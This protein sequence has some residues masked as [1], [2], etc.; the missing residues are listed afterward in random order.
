[1]DASAENLVA[2]SGGGRDF[3]KMYDSPGDDTF[4]SSPTAASLVGSG[5]SHTAYDFFAALGYATNREGDDTA[6]GND[7][8]VMADSAQKD[9]FKFDW[10]GPKQFFGK[11][12]EG[13][14]YYTRAK[15]FEEIAANMSGG[16]DLARLFGSEG[17]DTFH[18]QRDASQMTG[19]Q[20][21][22]TVTGYNSL[23]AYAENGV[24]EAYFDDSEENDT[25]R[26]RSL[27]VMMWG[28][29]YADPTYMLTARRFDAYH[30]ERTHGGDDLAKLHDTVLDDY[31][32]VDDGIAR[33]YMERDGERELLYESIAFEWVKLYSESDRGKNTFKSDDSI[34]DLLFDPQL[35]EEMP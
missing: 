34:D 28:G 25:V 20:Y 16:K 11:M 8:A 31:V 22:V 17:D 10:N 7:Q 18:G 32:E 9:K 33:F 13:G 6:G 35:W 1:M 3:I 5:Y 15:N 24:D 23:V 26:A 29:S 19:A 30:F 21:D 4:T 2:H 12:Y 14:I 27:K